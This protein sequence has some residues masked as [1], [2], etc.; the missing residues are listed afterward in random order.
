MTCSLFSPSIAARIRS[1]VH[2][3]L[4]RPRIAGI[5]LDDVRTRVIERADTLFVAS[6]HPERGLDVSHRGD[7]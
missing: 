4:E 5:A 2:S 6:R 7:A 1:G 3:G